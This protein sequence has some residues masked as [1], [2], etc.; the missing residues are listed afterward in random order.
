[1]PTPN[2]T[3]RD[4]VQL[5]SVYTYGEHEQSRKLGLQLSHIFCQGHEPI[6]AQSLLM[7]M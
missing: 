2:A 5:H 1:M 3:V 7:D 6:L 4:H